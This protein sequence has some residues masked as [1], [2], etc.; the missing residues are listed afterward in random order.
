[1]YWETPS[2]FNDA[3]ARFL[4]DVTRAETPATRT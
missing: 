3:V 1:M 4:E 2:M